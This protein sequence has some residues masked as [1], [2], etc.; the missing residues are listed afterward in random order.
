LLL[1]SFY[2][3]S[4]SQ[5]DEKTTLRAKSTTKAAQCKVH[6]ELRIAFGISQKIS[7]NCTATLGGDFNAR[8]LTNS[9][10][11]GAP[12]SLGFEVKLF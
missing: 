4:D 6:P 7:N 9:G 11:E 5:V 12:H 2:I 10:P 1:F 3:V 8:H